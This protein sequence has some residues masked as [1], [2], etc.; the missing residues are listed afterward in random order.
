MNKTIAATAVLAVVL[1]AC[2][3]SPKSFYDNPAKQ[4]VTA[5][6]RSVIET[7]DAKF[8]RD[9]AAE[10]TRRGMTLEGCQAKIN[11]QNTAITA[12]ALVGA[13]AAVGVIA[14]NG[15]GGGYAAP[16]KPAMDYDCMG[17]TGD[18]PLYIQGPVYVG[19]N[20]P[21][22]LDANKNGIGCEATDKAFGA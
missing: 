8:Q 22:R 6:C 9:V 13:V 1:S 3:T 10:L 5:L 12:I 18:G 19:S 20:D 11:Q 16:A 15:G 2:A 21:Y 17:G 7:K 4:D 14:A